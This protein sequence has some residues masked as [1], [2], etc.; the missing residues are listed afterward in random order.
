VVGF[1]WMVYLLL[2][3]VV[4]LLGFGV[5]LWVFGLFFVGFGMILGVVNFIIMIVCMWVLGLMMFWMLCMF[6]MLVM[7]LWV[8]LSSVWVW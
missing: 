1:G 7:F 5:D 4:Y 3:S 2:L 6:S 8:L